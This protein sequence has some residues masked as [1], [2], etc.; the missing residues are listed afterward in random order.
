VNALYPLGI[1]VPTEQNL[2]RIESAIPLLQYYARE[3]QAN[4]LPSYYA[5][6]P[7]VESMN[8][9]DA[10]SPKGALGVWQ[11]M[12]ETALNFGARV[13]AQ[14]DERQSIIL[15]TRY[16]SR[17]L[18]TLE[19]QFEHPIYVL[20]AYNWGLAGVN[21][22]RASFLYPE[23]LLTS[24]LVPQETRQYV[25][26][27]LGYWDTIIKI[28]E[29]HRLMQY[30]NLDYLSPIIVNNYPFIEFDNGT[31]GITQSSELQR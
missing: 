17:L 9:L 26:A 22:V 24:P 20:A 4:N 3:L 30:P 29:T 13:N 11:L 19:N 15:S 5:I 2:N 14:I 23:Q 16:A 28:Q 1:K 12:P 7:L 10:L 18:K 27:I 6:I 25:A 8:R 31:H 21:K